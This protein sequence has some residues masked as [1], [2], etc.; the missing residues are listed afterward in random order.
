[1]KKQKVNFINLKKLSGG[2]SFY[3][4]SEKE[5]LQICQQI[6]DQIQGNYSPGQ[7]KPQKN[8]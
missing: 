4:L 2:K 5:Q 1:M 6:L 3:E 7:K 8:D